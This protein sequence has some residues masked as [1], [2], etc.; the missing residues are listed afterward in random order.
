MT[1]SLP[2]ALACLAAA[3]LCALAIKAPRSRFGRTAAIALSVAVAV[4]IGIGT[5]LM[6]SR[7]QQTVIALGD[8]SEPWISV[9]AADWTEGVGIYVLTR[10]DP[11]EPPRLYT[12]PWHPALAAQLQQAAALARERESALRMASVFRLRADALLERTV[13]SVTPRMTAGPA[14]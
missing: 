13:F 6:L 1:A 12:L 8:T 7:P 10:P 9:L 14:R 11:N 5:L 4:A 3:L 2:F